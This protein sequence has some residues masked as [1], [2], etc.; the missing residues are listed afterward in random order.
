MRKPIAVVI[1]DLHF[2]INTVDIAG[3]ALRGAV[4]KAHM[5]G[6]PLVIAG[7]L[8]DTK[9]IIRAE[10]ANS[11]IEIL[12]SRENVKIFILEGNH[13]KI[14]EKGVGHGL[15]YLRPYSTVI[16][17]PDTSSYPVVGFLPYFSDKDKLVE[18]LGAFKKGSILIMH[19]GVA[20]AYMGDY[21]QDKSALDVD[22][23]KDFTCISGHYHRHQTIGTLTYIGSPYTV[24]F[25]EANDGGKGFLVLYQDGSFDRV[26]L[27]KLR[28]HRILER[29]YSDL[30]TPYPHNP[31]DLL[32]LKVKGPFSELEK[33]KKKDIGLRL[34]GH[35]NFKLDRLPVDDAPE[36]QMRLA[37]LTELQILDILIE[38]KTESVEQKSF[39]KTLAREIIT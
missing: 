7:D 26:L 32:W 9:A 39:L 18:A 13:D 4:N 15:N 31:G 12:Q 8:N 29:D 14:N 2:N 22:K 27:P 30:D 16:D 5:L 33:L 28:R 6:V 11:I 10:V 36:K 38:G 35:S 37:N 17:S 3:A 24:S 20:G 21:V 25:G 1:S 34:F 19:Q 23:L